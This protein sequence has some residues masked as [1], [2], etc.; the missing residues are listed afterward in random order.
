MP[1]SY[2]GLEIR[3]DRYQVYDSDDQDE[4]HNDD[5]APRSADDFSKLFSSLPG[6]ME[7]NWNNVL[8]EEAAKPLQSMS[9]EKRA[10]ISELEEQID[11]KIEFRLFSSAT[12][13][14]PIKLSRLRVS[15]PTDEKRLP[16]FVK[17]FRP[18]EYYLGLPPTQEELR[19]FQAIALSGP[20]VVKLSQL[21][22]P[23]CSMPW[24]VRTI[25]SSKSAQRMLR[26]F[27]SSRSAKFSSTAKGGHEMRKK[28]PGKKVRIAQRKQQNP[29][30]KHARVIGTAGLESQKQETEEER[31]KRTARNREK[32]QKR[33]VRDKARK[34]A[35]KMSLPS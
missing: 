29:K 13:K 20:D 31:Q 33:K 32:K 3:R 11:D 34:E 35:S 19:R 14:E 22:W 16:A 12:S 4:I 26:D 30:R 21:P 10:E 8:S 27:R 17:P 28:R 1:G 9:S 23:G 18:L 2:D 15:S 7:V 24:K 25:A 6:L 5:E